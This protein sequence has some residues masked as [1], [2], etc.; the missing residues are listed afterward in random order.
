VVHGNPSKD[1]TQILIS[2]A[3]AKEHF[4]SVTQWEELMTGLTQEVSHM[5]KEEI[6]GSMR[7]I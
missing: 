4:T 2:N 5:I 7:P 3:G 6:Q 1:R